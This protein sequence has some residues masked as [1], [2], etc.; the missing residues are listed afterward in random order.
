MGMLTCSFGPI[1]NIHQHLCGLHIYAHDPSRAVR[2]HHFCTHLR[3]D[4]HQ[5][6]IYD[7]DQPGARLIGVEYVIPEEAFEKLPQDEKKVRV[8]SPP[9]LTASRSELA[10]C[11]RQRVVA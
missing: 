9:A 5:C 7:S 11:E 4:L 10:T 1:N 6:V 3:P 2:A 8:L